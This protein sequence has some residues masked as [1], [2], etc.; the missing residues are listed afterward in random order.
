MDSFFNSIWSKSHSQSTENYILINFTAYNRLFDCK[1]TL[2]NSLFS[3]ETLFESTR[4]GVFHYDTTNAL[5]GA[6]SGKFQF[7]HLPT[8]LITFL[9]CSF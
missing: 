7:N 4:R 1:L 5:I 8:I 3:P 2:D 9:K 6:L